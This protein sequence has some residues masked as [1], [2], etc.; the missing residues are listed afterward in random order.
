MSSSSCLSIAGSLRFRFR[1]VPV[2]S[3]GRSRYD[4]MN[5]TYRRRLHNR[6]TVNATYTLSKAVAYDGN[7]A[8]FRNRAVN[9]FDYFNKYSLGPVPNDTRHRFSASGVIT[10][11]KGFQIA[12]IV[13]I[14]SARAYSPS[15]SSSDRRRVNASPVRI[16]PR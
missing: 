16:A 10:L 14:E 4:G 3:V 13:Q 9:H 11:P 2:A 1:P 8:A 12:P 7:S 5:V 15:A 6:V